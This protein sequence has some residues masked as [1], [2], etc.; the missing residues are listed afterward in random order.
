[1]IPRK[2]MPISGFSNKRDFRANFQMQSNKSYKQTRLYYNAIRP[3]VS[4]RTPE[5][6]NIK[7]GGRASRTSGRQPDSE[8]PTPEGLHSRVAPELMQPLQGRIGLVGLVPGVR[9]ARPPALLSNPSGVK[10]A[11]DPALN[12]GLALNQ[13]RK[14]IMHGFHHI[15]LIVSVLVASWM[16]MQAVHE[17]GR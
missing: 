14:I 8:Y 7:A 1:M 3:R 12:S 5:G 9:E 17:V 4:G 10:N 11:A 16:G 6:F 13:R 15:I 2:V